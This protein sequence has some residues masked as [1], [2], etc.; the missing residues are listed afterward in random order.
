MSNYI[1][2]AGVTFDNTKEDG[3][4]S[5]QTILKNIFE[6]QGSI[7]NVSL[8]ACN[9]EGEYAIKVKD[10]KSR[11][12]I[13]FIPRN[14]LRSKMIGRQM[15]AMIMEYKGVWSARLTPVEAPTKAQYH[16]MLM[17]CK[18]TGREMP[19]YDKRAYGAVFK[20]MREA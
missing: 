6:T 3:G 7:V 8:E 18:R 19:A 12:V 20:E 17:F 2:L 13:G 16:F 1:K 14:M 10:K 15:T 5:R 9:W 11:D 4:E